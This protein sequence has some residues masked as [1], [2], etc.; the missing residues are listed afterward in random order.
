VPRKWSLEISPSKS[1]MV[2][3]FDS[4]GAATPTF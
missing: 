1:A 2:L 4:Q 3:Q